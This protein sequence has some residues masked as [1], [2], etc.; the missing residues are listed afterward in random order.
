MTRERGSAILWVGLTG[1]LALFGDGCRRTTPEMVDPGSDGVGEEDSGP[2]ADADSGVVNALDVSGDRFRSCSFLS[3]EVDPS[4]VAW[5]AKGDGGFAQFGAVTCEVD[6]PPGRV[7]TTVDLLSAQTPREEQTAAPYSLWPLVTTDLMTQVRFGSSAGEWSAWAPRN[8]LQGGDFG[9][10][11]SNGIPDWAYVMSN[12]YDA[13]TNSIYIRLWLD[14]NSW[15]PPLNSG[16]QDHANPFHDGMWHYHERPNQGDLISRSDLPTGAT[17]ALHLKRTIQEVGNDIAQPLKDFVPPG[18][19]LTVSGWV[20][21]PMDTASTWVITRFHEFTNQFARVNKLVLLGDDDF[22]HGNGDANWTWRA[23]SFTSAPSTSHLGL[24]PLRHYEQAGEA[25]GANFEIREG[26]VFSE[27]GAASAIYQDRF[28]DLSKWTLTNAA[29]T[30]VVQSGMHGGKT[31]V[32]KPPPNE[33]ITAISK[34]QIPVQA[35]KLYSFRVYM[36]NDA[37]PSYNLTHETWVTCYLVFTDSAGQRIDYVKAL[38]YRPDFKT[39]VGAAMV[40]PPLAT[41]AQVVLAASHKS[42]IFRVLDK[43][44]TASFS[45]L[46]VEE[47]AYDRTWSPRSDGLRFPVQTPAGATKL[48]IRS[49]LYSRDVLVSPSFAGYEI[50]LGQ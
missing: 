43:T 13:G 12:L 11:N 1:T 45:A 9:D 15:P 46:Q 17:Q 20:R 37:D 49:R 44:L 23:L 3:V 19:P 14:S 4:G 34:T 32:L 6:L 24:Y 26:S 50:Q 38:V 25:W 27:W 40:A 35:G 30:S 5:L 42:L 18:T 36:Q 21:H 28:D 2:G 31:L 8:L 47:S 48:Q 16:M 33:V 22:L 10:E 29:A 7:A 41:R 39:P